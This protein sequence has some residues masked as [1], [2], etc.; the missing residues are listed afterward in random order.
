MLRRRLPGLSRCAL[1]VALL[2]G[3]AAGGGPG[4]RAE[5]FDSLGGPRVPISGH[6]SP[7]AAA[8]TTPAGIKLGF[9]TSVPICSGGVCGTGTSCLS[10][11]L[12][13][14]REHRELIDRLIVGSG[15]A[16][17]V[18]G[19]VVCTDCGKEYALQANIQSCRT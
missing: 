3:V 1:V 16:V 13:A 11:T 5:P 8:D 7:G 10:G 2:G 9:W 18:A 14:V 4:G 19:D 6:S 17:T 12:A 15:L